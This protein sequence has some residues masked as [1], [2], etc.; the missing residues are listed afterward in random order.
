M[1]MA[2]LSII[3]EAID[4]VIPLLAPV[5]ALP[6]I[7]LVE[8]QVHALP[9]ATCLRVSA[10]LPASSTVKAV[11]HQVHTLL[12]ATIRPGATSSKADFWVLVAFERFAALIWLGEEATDP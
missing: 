6:T 11:C 8:R 12:L 2:R 4:T 1:S 7:P 9:L 10:L 3:A 5:A